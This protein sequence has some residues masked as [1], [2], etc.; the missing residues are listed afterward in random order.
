MAEHPKFGA[1]AAEHDLTPQTDSKV[2][3]TEEMLADKVQTVTHDGGGLDNGKSIS[4]V[5]LD[6][7]DW[8]HAHRNSC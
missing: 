3:E 7:T 5:K 1:V 2:A 4:T 8:K 6:V